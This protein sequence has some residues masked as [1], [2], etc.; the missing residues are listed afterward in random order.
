MK[1]P[2]LLPL[3]LPQ[4]PRGKTLL[5]SPWKLSLLSHLIFS[6]LLLFDIHAPYSPV[7]SLLV[8]DFCTLNLTLVFFTH[9]SFHLSHLCYSCLPFHLFAFSNSPRLLHS[10]CF[11][12]HNSLHLHTFAIHFH[13]MNLRLIIQLVCPLLES[14]A[15]MFYF[16]LPYLNFGSLYFFPFAFQLNFI[17]LF[18]VYFLLIRFSLFMS[19]FAFSKL[20]ITLS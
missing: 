12:S 17:R 20:F 9:T 15:L 4:I 8:T 16:I 2:F 5:S 13:N 14:T 18:Q 1:R 3:H 6:V 10:V 19:S 7:V 11:V